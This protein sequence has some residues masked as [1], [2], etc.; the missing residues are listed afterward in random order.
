MPV[1]MKK[2]SLDQVLNLKFL[3]G[4]QREA[5]DPTFF[6][7]AVVIYNTFIDVAGDVHRPGLPARELVIY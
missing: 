4:V 5:S 1:Y 6:G 7:S 3:H 2:V